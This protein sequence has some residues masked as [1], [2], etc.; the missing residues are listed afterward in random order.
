[1]AVE[2]LLLDVEG[3]A[4]ITLAGHV[5]AD[6]IENMRAETM[7]IVKATQTSN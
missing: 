2:F 4:I 7:R 6:D 3:L 1:M 5:G